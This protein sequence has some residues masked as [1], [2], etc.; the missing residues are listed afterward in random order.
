MIIFDTRKRVCEATLRVS[1]IKVLYTLKIFVPVILGD[2]ILGD[3]ILI[4]Q[5]SNWT[6]F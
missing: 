3:N 4:G 1:Y 2:N 5:Y 6:I